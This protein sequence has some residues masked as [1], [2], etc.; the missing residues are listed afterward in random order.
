MQKYRRNQYRPALELPTFK[1]VHQGS[2]VWYLENKGKW[3]HAPHRCL[4]LEGR[5]S[6]IFK[7]NI[8]TTPIHFSFKRNTGN[9][10]KACKRQRQANQLSSRELVNTC[11]FGVLCKHTGMHPWKHSQSG[12]TGL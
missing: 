3:Y 12:R 1:A 9:K 8:G 10:N 7:I 11:F 5:Y 4:I 6:F 2:Q